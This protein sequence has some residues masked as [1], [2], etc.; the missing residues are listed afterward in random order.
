MYCGNPGI[1]KTYLCA[2][3]AEWYHK[4]FDTFRYWNEHQLLKRLR[5]VISEGKGDYLDALQ[6]AID[7]QFLMFDDMGSQGHNEWREEI[8]FA[9]IDQRYNSELPT[10]ITTNYS[11]EDIK[12]IY[13]P[14]LYSRL[15][16]KENTIIEIIDG[17]DLRISE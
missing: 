9:L 6:F 4:T 5:D 16:A 1:G 11:R 2:A 10:L 17:T 12:K 15:F 8:H 7:D 3:L 14:R 13:H